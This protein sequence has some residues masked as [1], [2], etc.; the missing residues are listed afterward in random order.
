MR[1]PRHPPFSVAYAAGCSQAKP[2]LSAPHPRLHSGVA[3]LGG[4]FNK[5]NREGFYEFS[6]C[7]PHIVSWFRQNRSKE[8]VFGVIPSLA[9]LEGLRE[10]LR[11]LTD[12]QVYPIRTCVHR[13]TNCALTRMVQHIS[14]P[15]LCA[16]KH[17]FGRR[18]REHPTARRCSTKMD[19]WGLFR[20]SGVSELVCNSWCRRS[21]C[22]GDT[23]RRRRRCCCEEWGSGGLRRAVAR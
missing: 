23:P 21:K 9:S 13:A 7:K 17:R 15:W 12:D 3:V 16:N 20:T 2:D 10:Q 14:D 1:G 19:R 11:S 6:S 22:P 4:I 5:G 18:V 8:V